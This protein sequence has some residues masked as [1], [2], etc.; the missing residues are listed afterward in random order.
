[1]KKR[2]LLFM[3]MMMLSLSLAGCNFPGKA[4]PTT[5]VDLLNTAAAQTIEAQ[6]T[7]IAQTHQA[8]LTALAP[9]NTL[10]SETGDATPTSTP[11]P[12]LTPTITTTKTTEKECDQA[13]FVSET[14]PDGTEFDPG[15]SFEKTWTLKNSGTCTWND[16]YDVVFVSGDAMDAP[17]SKQLTSGTVAPGQ[18]IQIELDLVAPTEAGEHLGEFML[19]N[20]SGV[21]FGI[22]EKDSKFWVEIE[23]GGTVYDFTE[24]FCASGVK[25]TSGAGTLSCP[26]TGGDSDGWVRKINEPT[27]ESGVVDNEPGLQVHPEMVND[28][29]IRGTFPEITITGDIVFKAIVGCYGSA[30]CDVD[31]KLNYK[32]DGGSEHTLAT[33][34]EVQDKD[35]NRVEVDLSSLEGEDVQFI[36]FVQANGTSSTDEALWFGPRIV[37]D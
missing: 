20:A 23:V 17:A 34:H 24:N 26:G 27:L 32:I 14:I 13:E 7:N 19:R 21:L 8:T 31:F 6:Q 4:T 25:W 30:D 37:P 29:W 36:L 22:G 16:D 12:S 18:S 33:W 9:T 3:C 5:Q 28:G 2:K 15:Q 1:M 11:Q 35:T 10:D